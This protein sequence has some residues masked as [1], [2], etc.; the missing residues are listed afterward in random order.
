MEQQHIWRVLYII[1]NDK[2]WE[3]IIDNVTD[4]IH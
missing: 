2:A 1:D 4:A 3:V